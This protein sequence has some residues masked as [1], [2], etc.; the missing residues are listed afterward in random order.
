MLEVAQTRVDAQVEL[1]SGER[2]DSEGRIRPN[3]PGHEGIQ[4]IV[5]GPT[6]T[7]PVTPI[8]KQLSSSEKAP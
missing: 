4:S 3:F 7:G 2:C 5:S 8:L 6:A 1:C